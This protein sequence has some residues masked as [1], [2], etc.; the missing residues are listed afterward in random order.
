ML[1]QFNEKMLDSDPLKRPPISEIVLTSNYWNPRY[2]LQESYKQFKQA[3][4]KRFELIQLEKLGPKFSKRHHSKAIFTS[5]PLSSLISK[6]SYSSS[7]I[8]INTRQ[9]IT[10]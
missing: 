5:R 3:E 8:T 9:G 4:S 6:S 1:G 10:F 7:M 2:D